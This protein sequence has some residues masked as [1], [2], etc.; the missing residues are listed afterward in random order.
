MKH[1][2]EWHTCDGCDNRVEE[3][4]L[5]EVQVVHPYGAGVVF[6]AEVCVT[7]YG[8]LQVLLD[9][10]DPRRQRMV[11]NPEDILHV[12]YAPLAQAIDAYAP[13]EPSVPTIDRTELGIETMPAGG[14]PAE[15][16]RRQQIAE[17]RQD[18]AFH[19]NPFES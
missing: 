15:Q 1:I 9:H 5:R 8:L 7:C 13:Y 18:I 2:D 10:A 3:A 19:R 16:R 11:R 17:G 14:M 6:T 4:T 12:S